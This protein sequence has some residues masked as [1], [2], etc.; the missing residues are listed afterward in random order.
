MTL[1]N[2]IRYEH[3]IA[4]Y[5]KPSHI[6]NYYQK[7]HESFL[8]R[9]QEKSLSVNWVEYFGK[10][11]VDDALEEICCI[12]QMEP[13]A[14]TPSP[15]G[16]FVVLNVACLV[17]DVYEYKNYTLQ[18][19]RDPEDICHESHLGIFVPR[20]INKNRQ[21]ALYI[22]KKILDIQQTRKCVYKVNC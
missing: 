7:L 10:D 9:P 22:R 21:V 18:V 1:N 3:S 19:K 11:T 13:C 8:L 15:N 12:M 16:G 6:K 14:F 20:D 5:C 2:G 17:D 4:R